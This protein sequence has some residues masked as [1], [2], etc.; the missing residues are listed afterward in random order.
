[1]EVVVAL[2]ILT[3]TMTAL[4]K[5]VGENA[6]NQSYLENRTFAQWVALNQIARLQLDAKSRVL[7]KNTGIE[8]MAGREWNWYSDIK[9]TPDQHVYKAEVSVATG[10]VDSGAIVTVV[11]YLPVPLK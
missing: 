6:A 2:A 8:L 5:G 3:I 1:M 9:A 11:G 4:V 10:H 7:G